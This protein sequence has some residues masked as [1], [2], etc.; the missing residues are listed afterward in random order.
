MKYMFVK[1]ETSFYLVTNFIF[2][3]SK[4]LREAKL[5]FTQ[6]KIFQHIH[7][8]TYGSDKREDNLYFKLLGFVDIY[9]LIITL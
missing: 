9:F 4:K 6:T 1:T 2:L 3:S 8:N 5:V 7:H